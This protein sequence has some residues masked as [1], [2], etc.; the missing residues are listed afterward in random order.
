MVD[1]VLRRN[2]AIANVFLEAGPKAPRTTPAPRIP[3][4]DFLEQK[5]LLHEIF[6]PAS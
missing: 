2:T 4:P 3:Q 5:T 6:L 1:T